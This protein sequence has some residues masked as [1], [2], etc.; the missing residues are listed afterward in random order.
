MYARRKLLANLWAR[1]AALQCGFSQESIYFIIPLYHG[2]IHSDSI[3]DPSRLSAVVVQVMSV[4]G[5]KIV[6][7]IIRPFGVPRDRHQP[8]PYLVILMDLD[9]SRYANNGLKIYAAPEPSTD[10]EFGILCDALDA[11]VKEFETYR[12]GKKTEK[13]ILEGLKKKIHDARLAVDSCN[14]YSMSVC[15]VSQREYG[16]LREAKIE[17]E[18]ATLVEII[19]PLPDEEHNTREH[20]WPLERLSERSAWMSDYGVSNEEWRW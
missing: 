12:S 1:G 4:A 16:I 14:R 6:E 7:P 9:E 20:V 5:G 17:S 3:F 18:F 19:M 13:E 10:G 15:G 8:L 11:A 2:S